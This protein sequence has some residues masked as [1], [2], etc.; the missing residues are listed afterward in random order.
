MESPFRV[1]VSTLIATHG[2]SVHAEGNHAS[3]GFVPDPTIASF[4][5]GLQ[6]TAY[7]MNEP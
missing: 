2:R 5:D 7:L 3:A 1:A 4:T 6:E